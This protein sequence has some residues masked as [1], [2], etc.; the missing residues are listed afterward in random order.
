M[1]AEVRANHF[2]EQSRFMALILGLVNP[3]SLK[4]LPNLA[5][6][7]VIAHVLNHKKARKNR[8]FFMQNGALKACGLAFHLYQSICVLAPR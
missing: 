5:S 7:A 6:T 1:I 8:A 2:E 4:L 3:R